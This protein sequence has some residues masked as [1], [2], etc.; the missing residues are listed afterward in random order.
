MKKFTLG[1]A[2]FLVTETRSTS[3]ENEGFRKFFRH[4]LR[5]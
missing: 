5:I 3:H 1:R 4:G 2:V